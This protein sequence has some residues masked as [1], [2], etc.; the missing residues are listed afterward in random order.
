MS[1]PKGKE[2]IRIAMVDDDISVRELMSNHIN[3]L[4]NCKVMIQAGE[5]Q[6]LLDKLKINPEIDLVILDIMMD[7]LDGYA[8]AAFIRTDYK[9]MRI[10][11]YSVCKTELALTQMATSGGHGLIRKGGSLSKMAEAIRIVMGGT[12]FFPDMEEKIAI[13][14]NGFSGDKADRNAMLSAAEVGFLQW[15]GSEKTDKEIADQLKIKPRQVD[16]IREGLFK[17]LHVKNRIAL[18][19]LAYQSGIL[20]SGGTA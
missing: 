6:E 14:G 17:R 7:G 12:Y 13:K 11:F 19:I 3:T 20:Q 1:T 10:I 15:I 8:T 4:D 5:G 18:A 2:L 9:D 16:Y